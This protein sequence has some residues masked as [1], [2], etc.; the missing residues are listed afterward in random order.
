MSSASGTSTCSGPPMLSGS[1]TCFTS[2]GSASESTARDPS[3]PERRAVTG[4]GTVP[5]GVHWSE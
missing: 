1:G 2:T 3:P 4:S 5:S